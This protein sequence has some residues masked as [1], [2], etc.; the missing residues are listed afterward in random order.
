MTLF[1][2]HQKASAVNADSEANGFV[3]RDS[4]TAPKISIQ[5]VSKTFRN[6]AG[7]EVEAIRSVSF[8]VK[9]REFVALV[10]P[11]GGGKS[12]LL[13]LSAGLYELDGGQILMDGKKVGGLQT[14]ISYMP[15]RDALL[16]WRTVQRNV[17]YGLEL[18]GFSKDD[19]KKAAE[20]MIRHVGLDGAENRYPMQ[21]SSGMRQRVAVAR[22][23]V[24]QPDILLMDEPF[25]A[26]DAQTRIKV[27][28]LFLR[29]WEENRATVLLVTHDVGE[30]I[31]L[32]DRIIVLSSSPATVRAEV[33][34]PFERPRELRRMN[35]DPKYHELFNQLLDLLEETEED[36]TGGQP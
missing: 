4:P 15:S 22:T 2:S 7:E 27:Q 36:G 12:T 24:C 14:N 3:P 6:K 13:N 29:L 23:F 17:E 10:G 8:D 34:V 20:E 5:N 33:V 26:L 18:R 30:A 28:D 16:P 11:S 9:E 32:A 25:S 35:A 21:L 1:D 19:R 31:A